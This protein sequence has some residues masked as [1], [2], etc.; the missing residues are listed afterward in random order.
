MAKAEDSESSPSKR[1]LFDAVL[2]GAQDSPPTIPLLRRDPRPNYIPLPHSLEEFRRQE[3][4]DARKKRLRA[5]W[6]KLPNPNQLEAGSD[7]SIIPVGDYA[8]L[9]PERAARLKQMY[10]S[11]LLVR[12]GPGD[13]AAS[14][15]TWQEFNYYAE[16]KEVGGYSRFNN[17]LTKPSDIVVQSSGVS[18]TMSWT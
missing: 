4:R 7:D 2:S 8:S 10:E 5:L 13:S 16:A 12:C 11:E 14:L 17:T 3:G 6:E 9:T 1:K 15:P 18:S